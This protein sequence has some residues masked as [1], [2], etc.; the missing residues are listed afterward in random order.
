MSPV[1]HQTGLK[2][3][4]LRAAAFVALVCVVI[5]GM[6]GWREWTSRE[7][8]LKAVEVQMSNLARSLTQHAEDT[9]E[10]AETLLVGIVSG[11]ETDGAKPDKIARI[12]TI[13]NRRKA[14]LGR[15]HG[16]FVYDET[17]HWLATTEAVNLAEYDNSDREYFQYHRG[18]ADR[19][20]HIGRPVQSRSG[21][22]WVTTLSRRWSHPDGSFGGVVLA[23]VDAA[24]FSNFYSQFDTGTNGALTLLSADGIVMARSPDN[25]TYVGRDTSSGPLFQQPMLQSRQ[26]EHYFR[27]PLDGM[28]R[29]SF[30]QRSERFPLVVLATMQQDEVLAPWRH[31]AVAR[32]LFVLGLVV[33][34][35]VIG[36]FLVRQ[37]L[38]GQRM[39]AALASKEA[40][41]RLLAEGSSDM[42]TRIGL[43]ERLHYVSPST[44]R[45]VGWRPD[46]LVGTPA[47]AGVNPEDLPRVH[48]IVAALKRGEREEA[49]VSYRTRHR[50][51]SEIWIEST[52]RVTRE[53]SGAIDGVVAISRDMTEQKDAEEKLAALATEDG[54]TGIAN[55]RRFDEQLRE[56]W[57]RAARDRTY[58]SLLMVDIDHF[59]TFN[60]TYGH[61][62]GD[63]CLRSVARILTAEAQR[64]ADLAARYGGEE[65]VILLPNTDATGCE[66]IAQRIRRA[67]REAGM[68]H[69][70]NLPSGVVTVSIGG[71][72]CQPAAQRSTD[73]ASL[74]EAADRALYAAKNGGRDRL[75]MSGRAVTLLP[76]ASTG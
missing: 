10:L 22:Q 34:I 11:L 29:V 69:G 4:P 28:Q 47:L 38:Q 67:I 23:T 37:L 19:G 39:A 40:N 3:L 5:V 75:V 65:F 13:L 62:A 54:L 55:R 20:I 68:P 51:K 35:A 72:V 73:E 64:P 33:L 45:V 60:D 27:S 1:I 15:I 57:S 41:F 52:L 18:S 53:V 59:K 9:V 32:I 43:D 50:E 44:L 46:Q 7:A 31:A 26:G 25:G 6:S 74:I 17:G 66:R 24:Y 61:P 58:L 14:G 63:E 49:R 21:G 2:R 8:R 76:V 48:E 56:E 30:Y 36:L 16:L 42:V 70:L 71:A 12:Q